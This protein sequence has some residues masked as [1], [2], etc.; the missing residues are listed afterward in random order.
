M[1]LAVARRTAKSQNRACP[2]SWKFQSRTAPVNVIGGVGGLG[3]PGQRTDTANLRL[4]KEWVVA[5]VVVFQNR[6]HRPGAATEAKGVDCVEPGVVID[7][8]SVI[9]AR[10]VLARQRF[11]E[12]Y[13]Q[14]VT[15]GHVVSARQHKVIGE[16]VLRD[17]GCRSAAPQIRT[18]E[19]GGYV[20]LA[21]SE[22]A[23]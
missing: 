19:V 22:R 21:V 6:L 14:A 17:G 13:P 11:V 20:V 16:W 18:G 2:P 4:G 10:L 15:G 12:H 1:T 3:M 8:V 9:P 7:L 5:E 23:P